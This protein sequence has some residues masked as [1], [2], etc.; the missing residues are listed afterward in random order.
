M[1]AEQDR[2]QF[3]TEMHAR[4]QEK[5]L[6]D[7]KTTLAVTKARKA[8]LTWEEV[9]AALGITRQSAWRRYHTLDTEH[10]DQLPPAL[11]DDA[12]TG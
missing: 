12:P 8:G 7:Q 1:S 6:A 10:Q 4:V 9:G 11:D 5:L 3:L 2:T